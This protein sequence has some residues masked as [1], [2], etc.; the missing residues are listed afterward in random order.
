MLTN[1]ATEEALDDAVRAV[2]GANK[3]QYIPDALD[4]YG[5]SSVLSERL[6]RCIEIVP[7]LPT[8]VFDEEKAEAYLHAMLQTAE[9]SSGADQN[10]VMLMEDAV[11]PGKHSY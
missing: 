9:P 1:A 10:K 6:S 7:G 4:K 5:A 2:A 3:N 8:K 11:Q